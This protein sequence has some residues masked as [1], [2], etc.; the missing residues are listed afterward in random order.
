MSQ[1]STVTEMMDWNYKKGDWVL[2]KKELDQG[3]KKWSN[4][5]HWSSIKIENKIEQF[6]N[7]LNN[8]LLKLV[9]KKMQTVI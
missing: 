4:A 7:E 2:F 6:L 1:Q 9:P 3:L 8:A 5:R